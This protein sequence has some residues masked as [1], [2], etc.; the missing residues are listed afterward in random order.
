MTFIKSIVSSFALLDWFVAMHFIYSLLHRR[1]TEETNLSGLS[2]GHRWGAFWINTRQHKRRNNTR[3]NRQKTAHSSIEQYM[4][5]L[6]W[7]PLRS[8]QKLLLNQ[9]QTRQAQKQ[10][11]KQQTED[12]SQQYW[13]IPGN[14]CLGCHGHRWGAFKKFYWIKRRNKTTNNR[15]NTT[16]RREQTA[17]LRIL[18]PMPPSGRGPRLDRR[19]RI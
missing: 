10:D 15:Q 5:W 1:S 19:A 6:S 3:N 2:P 16:D 11:N 9:H 7:P 4:S 14:I 17:L 8:L 12:S 18:G 13:T